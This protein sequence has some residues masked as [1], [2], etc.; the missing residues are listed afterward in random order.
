MGMNRGFMGPISG[1]TQTDATSSCTI[2]MIYPGYNEEF[3]FSGASLLF[4]VVLM[5]AVHLWTMVSRL[6]VFSKI[7]RGFQ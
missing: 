4:R 6:T 5:S 3:L 1:G 2:C 7:T